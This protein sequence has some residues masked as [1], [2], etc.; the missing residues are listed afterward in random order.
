MPTLALSMIV[1]DAAQHL[2]ECLASVRDVVDEMIVAD[3]GSADA[4]PE[5]ARC[6]GARVIPI[7][8]ENDFAKARNLSLAHVTADWVLMI[9]A[10]ERLDPGAASVLPALMSD[11]SVAGYQVTIR[12]YVPS[13]KQKLWSGPAKPNDSGYAPAQKYP[14]YFEHRNVRLF[15]R[16]PA[17]Y[18]TGYVHETVGYRIQE[19]GKKLG[20][21]AF[22]IHHFGFVVD[23]Q[24]VIRKLFF[25]RDLGLRKIA[26][27][28]N[29]ARAHFELGLVELESLGKAREALKYF[30]RACTLEPVLGVARFFTGKCQYQLGYYA[31]AI[32]SLR[33][34]ESSGHA[35]PLA[36]ELSGDAYCNIGDYA[37][38]IACYRRA[39]AGSPA[40][41]TFLSKLGLAEARSGYASVGLERLRDAIKKEPTNIESHDRLIAAE[42]WLDRLPE[43]AEAAEKKLAAVPPQPADYLRAANMR[44]RM[45]EW[46]RAEDILRRGL[47][48]FPDS[49]PL[50]AHLSKAEATLALL[51]AS[52]E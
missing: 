38:A 26:E 18:F 3:T 39:L 32:R 42:E 47:A 31:N 7:S 27:K 36:A 28:P 46:K 21:A 5:I 41:A 51:R 23:E 20:A 24:T 6:A 25:Y 12:N 14:A 19:A 50:R 35:T 2:A 33:R 44:A 9:D 34:A 37:A 13:L 15:R 40:S 30:E 49:E 11:E 52:S 10:D 48:I 22:L 17:V 16:D 29:D 8:W 1:K 43:A 45:A 4:S